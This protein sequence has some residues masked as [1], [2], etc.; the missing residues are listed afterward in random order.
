[1]DREALDLNQH[2]RGGVGLDP[3]QSQIIDRLAFFGPGPPRF[4]RDACRV[5]NGEVTLEAATHTVAHA[6][7]EVDSSIRQ[8]LEPMVERARAKQI[9]AIERGSH[10]AWIQELV[11]VL[12]FDD[13]DAAAEKWWSVSGQL[14]DWVHRDALAMPRPLDESFRKFWTD[15]QEL[16]EV[17]TRR[18]AATFLATMPLIDEL[19]SKATPTSKDVTQLRA[20]VP[21]NTVALDRFFGSL[22]SPSWLELLRQTDY[23]LAPEPLSRG[24]DGSAIYTRWPPGDY[25]VRMAALPSERARVIAIALALETDNPEAHERVTEAALAMPATHSVQLVEK[26]GEFLQTPFQW[27]LPMKATELAKQ[28]VVGGEVDASLRLLR[29][30]LSGSRVT[31]DSWLFMETLEQSREA[32]FPAAGISGIELLCDLLEDA[33]IARND[34][35]SESSQDYSYIWRPT[36]EHGR[37]HEA[38]DVLVMVLHEASRS[39][40]G[41][42]TNAL[43]ALIESLE[44]RKQAIFK[45][46]ALGLLACFPEG[47]AEII[48]ARLANA[49][50]F[51][52]LHYRC[53]Y[54]RLAKTHFGSLDPV[55]Q[56]R[57]LTLIELGH[58]EEDLEWRERWQLNELSRLGRPLPADWER[59]YRELAA[60]YPEG[61]D[62]EMLAEVGFVGPIAPLA[63]DELAAMTV[64]EV[65]Q[66]LRDW[67]P[68]GE[69]RAPTAEGLARLLD[70]VVCEAPESHAVAAEEYADVDPT[71]ARAV[72]SG[73][74]KAIADGRTFEW[75]PVLRL[76]TL[77]VAKPRLIEGRDENNL[78]IDPGWK[79]ARKEVANLLAS[80]FQ[81]RP[82]FPI[83]F[84][85]EAFDILRELADDPNPAFVDEA[86][87]EGAMDPATLSLN[88][89]RGAAFHAIMG[90][91]WWLYKTR[92]AAALSSAGLPQRVVDLLERHL[93]P[94][95]EPTLTI[96]SVYGQWFPYLATADPTWAKARVGAIFPSASEQVGLRNIAWETYVTFNRAYKNTLELLRDEYGRTI[97]SLAAAASEGRPGGRDQD[98]SLADH[99]LTL[100][101][102]GFIELDDP[103]LQR[104]F[105]QAPLHLRSRTIEFVGISLSNTPAMADEAEARFRALWEWRFATLKEGGTV[106]D[107]LKGFGWWFSSSKLDDTWS[108]AQLHD[109]L[110]HGG[111][112]EPEHSVAAR[113]AELGAAHVERV[114]ICLSL[115]LDAAERRWFVLGSR[116]EIRAILWLGLAHHGRANTTARETIN[117]L[118]AQGH[119]EFAELLEPNAVMP[120]KI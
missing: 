109:L 43:P 112:V 68:D 53:E 9:N 1:V 31:R 61:E 110:A 28:L 48:G 2:D 8:V 62:R 47:H 114:V 24:G 33:M 27:A 7:R 96:R 70:D 34:A 120:N 18:F 76:A 102:H 103:L 21:N 72:I 88:T 20:R 14:Y 111:R 4:F 22:K 55:R 40:A 97:E 38:R 99:L 75:S 19:A 93:D 5:M 3:R 45:R 16:Y 81:A 73:F 107:E 119:V 106:A 41:A 113:L 92:E 36:L 29:H 85:D 67:K 6:L 83:E 23:F 60:R 64:E 94:A 46:L 98:E 50:L 91:A 51:T 56:E 12:A 37:Q 25:L 42:D 57:I 71:Y 59:R 17:V 118:A 74:Q 86:E 104:F 87:R 100:Y 108:L 10:K 77:V 84:A 52:D 30:V 69:W 54:D 82:S 63:K 58:S 39:V 49:S 105:L 35:T 32:F 90:Y 15:A 80:A 13:P 11:R 116:D 115:L 79:W 101:G 44:S 117:R 26:I 66:L 89:V 95:Y 78:D 65:L